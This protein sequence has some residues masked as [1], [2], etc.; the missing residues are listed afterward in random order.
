MI[1]SR[2]TWVRLAKQ[3]DLR[4]LEAAAKVDGHGVI[5]PT[6]IVEKD[7][8]IV[9]Y[10]SLGCVPTIFSWMDKDRVTQRDS[11]TTLSLAENE[12]ALRVG[13]GSLICIQCQ[14]DSPF[15]DVLTGLGYE[16]VGEAT[17]FIKKL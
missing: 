12:L 1:S 5:A 17:I 15:H 6:H 16:S 13:Q 10:Y 8:T 14:K 3:D 2:L 4:V 11:L 9:G 7:Q